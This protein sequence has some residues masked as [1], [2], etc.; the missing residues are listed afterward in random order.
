M[1]LSPIA[2]SQA[3]LAPALSIAFA[4]PLFAQ[5]FSLAGSLPGGAEW[6]EGIE[7]ADVD[8]DGDLDLFTANGNG[9]IVPGTPLP[10]GLLINQLESGPGV[11]TDESLARLG[12]K[13]CNG[14]NVHTADVDGD[15]WT[16]ALISSAFATTPPFLYINRGD[17]LPGFFDEEGESRG[18]TLLMR[19]AG[20]TFGDVD[21]DGDLDLVIGDTGPSFAGAPG[22]RP[23][24]FINDGTGNFTEDPAAITAPLKLGHLDVDLVDI[25]FD[26]DLDLFGTNRG[27]GPNGTHHLLLNDGMGA[28]VDASSLVPDTSA[29]VYEADLADLDGDQDLDLFFLS[30]VGFDE[31]GMRNNL[32]E[33]G[34]LGFAAGPSLGGDDDNEVSFIDH[35]MDGDLDVVIGS[36]GPTEKLIRNDGNGAFVQVTDVIANISDRTLDVAV[37]DLDN[38]G[39]YDLATAQGESD[40]ATWENKVFVNSGPVD[41]AAPRLVRLEELVAPTPEG[42]WVVRG[43]VRDEVHD[44]GKTWVDGRISYRVDQGLEAGVETDG[45]VLVSSGAQ[46]R[47]AMTDTA[48]GAGTRLE[49]RIEL[50]DWA[51]NSSETTVVE[52]LVPCGFST[53]GNATPAH[54]LTLTG[55]NPGLINS[56]VDLFTTGS[57]VDTVFTGVALDRAELPFAGGLLLIDITTLLLV[58][59]LQDFGGGALWVLPTPDNLALVGVP[60]RFQ[61][62]TFD[63]SLLGGIAFSNGLELVLCEE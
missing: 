36:L 11:F 22:G 49:Y 10:P 5:Q 45:E 52:P 26:W 47:F 4:S 6:T 59:S 44:D 24:L 37:A 1:K 40:P 12:P 28:F 48:A 7:A 41:T 33:N 46:Y 57:N 3:T 56:S 35:D 58:Q 16:D 62:I 50:T 43:L 18:L 61:S 38:D 8:L 15:G 21:N 51:G 32:I 42:P 25:D 27:T 60:L 14:K 31:G 9:L 2:R 39:D 55:L 17:D 13:A 54:T 23:H 30:L 20:S 53:Y 34:T 63:P 19:A 29:S